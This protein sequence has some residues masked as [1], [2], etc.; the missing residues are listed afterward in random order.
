MTP[1]Q[2]INLFMQ[3]KPQ[4]RSFPEQSQYDYAIEVISPCDRPGFFR[5]AFKFIVGLTR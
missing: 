1:E 5:R 4:R 2:Y 3:P